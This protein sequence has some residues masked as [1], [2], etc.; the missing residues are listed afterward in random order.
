MSRAPGLEV[1]LEVGAKRVFASALDWPGWCRSGK[2]E[3]GAIESLLAAAPRYAPVA[4]MAGLTLPDADRGALTVVERL[5]GTMTTDFGAPG[6]PAEA[7]SR[8]LSAGEAARLAALVGAAWSLLDSVAAA[9]PAELR[10][11][12]RGGGRDRDKVMAHELDA[13]VSYARK[14]GVRGMTVS[15]GDPASVRAFREAVLGVLARPW[16]GEAVAESPWSPRYLARRTAWHALDHAW[17][18]E[19]RTP[20]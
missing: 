17:E 7:E 10:K 2:G 4:E 16:S 18:I 5:P 9:A 14:I 12:P 6:V 15:A 1:C 11:G 8:P 3:E 20:G 13:A 19:D